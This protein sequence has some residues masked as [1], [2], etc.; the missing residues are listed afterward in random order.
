MKLNIIEAE[1]R[2]TFL[3]AAGSLLT[4]LATG[5]WSKAVE[6]LLSTVSS[7]LRINIPINIDWSKVLS[8]DGIFMAIRDGESIAKTLG[9]I[10][11]GVGYTVRQVSVAGSIDPV[12]LKQLLASKSIQ[13]VPNRHLEDLKVRAEVYK[14]WLNDDYQDVGQQKMR[15]FIEKVSTTIDFD[16]RLPNGNLINISNMPEFEEIV[17]NPITA[18][19]DSYG[20]LS[21]TPIFKSI[22]NFAKQIIK[23]YQ[24]SPPIPSWYRHYI[25]D[26]GLLSSDDIREIWGKEVQRD[27]EQALRPDRRL[28]YERPKKPEKL[29]QYHPSQDDYIYGSSMHQTFESKLNSILSI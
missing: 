14:E 9:A 8:L 2:R 24:L 13:I 18:W 23:R 6:N 22:G 3:K 29:E 11:D 28:K 16:I 7:P 15:A 26:G 19:W 12:K 17:G 27:Y 20:R 4:S 10:P 25:G 1:N 5:D 21:P